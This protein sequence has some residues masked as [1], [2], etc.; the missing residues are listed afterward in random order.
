MKGADPSRTTDVETETTE[1]DE[2][3]VRQEGG[4]RKDGTESVNQIRKGV[5]LDKE[6]V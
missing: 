3:I 4:L 1:P 2:D 5:Q 6:R